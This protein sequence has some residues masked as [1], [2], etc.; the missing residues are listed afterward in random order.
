VPDHDH[1]EIVQY[2]NKPQIMTPDMYYST[3]YDLRK[4]N[5]LNICLPEFSE[6]YL[7]ESC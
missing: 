5:P 4:H 2:P 6:S 1:A 3:A 7:P